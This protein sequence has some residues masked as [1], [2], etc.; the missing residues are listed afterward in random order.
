MSAQIPNSVAE[1]LIERDTSA[2]RFERFCVDLLS[3]VHGI[4][5]VPTS[6]SWDLGRDGRS[7]GR[8][9]KEAP[10]ICCTLAGDLEKKLSGDIERLTSAAKPSKVTCCSAQRVSEH[11]LEKLKAALTNRWAS[12]EI[13]VLGLDQLIVLGCRYPDSLRKWYRGE[14]ADLQDLIG[15]VDEASEQ[16]QLTGMRLALTTQLTED[17]RE[18]SSNLVENLILTALASS[19]RLNTAQIAQFASTKLRLPRQVQPHY[20]TK[21]LGHLQQGALVTSTD[22]R[23]ELSPAGQEELRKRASSGSRAILTGRHLVRDDLQHLLA[24]ELADDEFNCLWKIIRDHLSTMFYDHGL[25]IASSIA[26][27][28]DGKTTIQTHTSLSRALNCLR[29]DVDAALAPSNRAPE[30]AQAVQDLFHETTSPTFAWLGTLCAVYV[31]ICSLGLIP[32]AQDQILQRLR[33]IDLLLDT[34]VVLS[35]LCEGERIHKSV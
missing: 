5:Y 24:F 9:P 7:T 10:F 34:D 22:G 25:S 1:I 31:A 18:L 13:E 28:I 17:A 2:N 14:L 11:E 12:F 8:R 16:G 21:A 19:P 6:Q 35:F 30:I 20:F 15:V 3:E 33:E 23:F 32:E 29:E 27:V 4:E 26:S